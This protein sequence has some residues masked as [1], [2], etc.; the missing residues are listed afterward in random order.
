MNRYQ[1][2]FD[3]SKLKSLEED[4]WALSLNHSCYD[5]AIKILKDFQREVYNQLGDDELFDYL[6]NAKKRI[7]EL[8]Y[9]MMR[10]RR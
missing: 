6:E 8:R 4:T 5:K 9:K 1:S 7:E 2:K 10:T 3:N